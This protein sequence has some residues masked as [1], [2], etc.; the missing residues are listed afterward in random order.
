MY[1]KPVFG[2][3]SPLYSIYTVMVN[4]SGVVA[5]KGN[6]PL[7]QSIACSVAGFYLD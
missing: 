5:G 1:K 3:R 7:C 4:G 6:R 2:E